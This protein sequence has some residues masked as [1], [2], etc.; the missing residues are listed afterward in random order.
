MERAELRRGDAL[1][2]PGFSPVTY[3]LDVRLDELED[4]PAAVTVHLGTADVPAR[5]ARAGDY[6]QLR[7]ERPVVAARG[8][9]VVLRARTTVGGGRVLDPSP[10]RPLDPQ[11]LRP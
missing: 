2:E 8:D 1:V 4:V 10:P 5:V 11:R 7:L 9:R 6:A 3:R